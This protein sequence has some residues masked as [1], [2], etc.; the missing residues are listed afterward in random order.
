M[1]TL[2]LLAGCASREE[3]P[4]KVPAKKTVTEY[5]LAA[6]E[7]TAVAETI[8]LPA[9]LAAWQEVSI[10]PKVNG[11]VK[12][13]LVD[14][15]SHVQKGSL[16]MVLEAPELEQAVLQARERYTRARADLAIDHE[17]Y[18]RLQEAARTPGAISPLDLSTVHAKI[19]ADSALANAEKAN[20]QAQQSLQNYLRVTAPFDGVITERN[21]HPGALVSAASREKPMLELKQIDHL[22]LQVEIPEAVAAGVSVKDTLSFFTSVDPG[23]ALVGHITRQSNNIN[24]QL[25]TERVEADVENR[26][27][28]LSPGMYAQVLF[29]NNG[30]REAVSVPHTALVLSTERK[31]VLQKDGAHIRKIDVRSGNEANGRVEVFGNLHT[32]DSV[33]VHANDE[34]QEHL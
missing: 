16:L 32:G 22:R 9:Q 26:D 7:K 31:Y 24:A 25:R 5:Q 1:L 29:R 4:A 8:K 28:R 20:W 19:E 11:Y 3:A 34:I 2:L 30:S 23:R 6:V 12:Q 17:R 10:F 27:K 14:I 21:V 18:Q 13:V 33:I 15:G